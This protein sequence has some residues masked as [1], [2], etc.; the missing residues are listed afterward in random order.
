MPLDPPVVNQARSQPLV[1][2]LLLQLT[3]ISRL[4]TI[5]TSILPQ[6]QHQ[7]LPNLLLRRLHKSKLGEC[8][9]LQSWTEHPLCLN[10]TRPRSPT[11]AV[12]YPYI[13]I[14]KLPPR[15]SSTH[16]SLSLMYLQQTWV[17][18]SKSSLISTRMKLS[19]TIFSKPGMTG[20]PSTKTIPR[21]QDP[22]ASYLDH[23]L[24]QQAVAV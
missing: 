5:L 10:T 11:S 24:L 23:Q 21:C 4:L 1:T 3:T 12:A 19:V 8:S 20:V 2:I 9:T 22:A 6:A 16:L 18:S 13:N 7:P 17:S 15:N 14:P